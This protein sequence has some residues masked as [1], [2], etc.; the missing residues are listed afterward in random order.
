MIRPPAGIRLRAIALAGLALAAGC[1][2]GAERFEGSPRLVELA[3]QPPPNVFR[4]YG[5]PGAG[6]TLTAS[7]A[8]AL[9]NELLA[10]GR[11]REAAIDEGERRALERRMAALRRLAADAAPH[12]ERHIEAGAASW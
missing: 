11:A 9:E 2:T 5:P 8:A 1:S 4:S 10:L 3:D 6:R 7:Q 12:R